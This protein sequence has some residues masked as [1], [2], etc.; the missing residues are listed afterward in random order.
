[1]MLFN[2]NVLGPG[3]RAGDAEAVVLHALMRYYYVDEAPAV[4]LPTHA[5]GDHRVPDSM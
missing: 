1:M 3:A 4:A 5:S 2:P